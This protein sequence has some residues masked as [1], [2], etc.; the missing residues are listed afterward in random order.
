MDSKGQP[1]LPARTGNNSGLLAGWSWRS[2]AKRQKA[3]T[4]SPI[5]DLT[6]ASP[7]VVSPSLPSLPLTTVIPSFPP[8]ITSPTPT[9]SLSN[10]LDLTS[11]SPDIPPETTAVSSS[12]TLPS[13]STP[14]WSDPPPGP[15]VST[16]GVPISM[17]HTESSTE[18]ASIPPPSIPLP[19]STPAI[20]ISGDFPALTSTVRP[21]NTELKV[22][23][24][25]LDSNPGL[26]ST[27]NG[28]HEITPDE[29]RQETSITA[30][31]T[32][33]GAIVGSVLVVGLVLSGVAFYLRH[34]ASRKSSSRTIDTTCA[35]SDVSP[36]FA[37]PQTMGQRESDMISRGRNPPL[38][39]SSAAPVG[40]MESDFSILVDLCIDTVCDN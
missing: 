30:H 6:P 18:T 3:T 36:Y 9:P 7:S 32:M 34:R 8:V 2:R 25:G 22:I 31:N 26:N 19:T 40:P 21:T 27:V 38:D 17:Y 16:S 37:S 4:P 35:T 23:N 15:V 24:D 20:F 10:V 33:I 28:I 13:E 11:P 5:V 1:S 14:F 39:R 29:T 12:N